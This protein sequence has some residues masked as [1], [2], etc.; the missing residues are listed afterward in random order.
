MILAISEFPQ[1]SLLHSLHF[2]PATQRS[3]LEAV[4]M[5]KSVDDVQLQLAHQRTAERPCVAAR[6]LDTDKNFAVL[7]REHVSGPRFSEKLAMQS[8]YAPIGN[9]PDKNFAQLAQIS[10]FSLSQSQATLHG[11]CGKLFKLANIDWDF[12]LKVPHPDAGK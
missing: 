12:S 5:Q 9:E 1:N 3:I 4:Q 7:K 2:A 8:R 6:R 11:C 10:S